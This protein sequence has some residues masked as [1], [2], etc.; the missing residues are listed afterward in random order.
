MVHINYKVFIKIY[1]GTAEPLGTV[2][3][4]LLF[5]LWLRFWGDFLL[6]KYIK[7]ILSQPNFHSFRRPWTMLSL[8]RAQTHHLSIILNILVVGKSKKKKKKKN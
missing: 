2:G 4:K 3:M 5:F 7:N 8:G 6:I 1:A